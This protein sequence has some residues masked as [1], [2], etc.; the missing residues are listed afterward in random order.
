MYY[1]TLRWSGTTSMYSSTCCTQLLIFNRLTVVYTTCT[2]VHGGCP[3]PSMYSSTCSVSMWTP[4]VSTLTQIDT[5][6][7]RGD[8][9]ILAA[10]RAKKFSAD[11]AG[12]ST[13]YCTNL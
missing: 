4:A 2:T 9:Y 12:A 11:H 13:P 10:N 3:A 7:L 6:P 1:C 5:T 8:L